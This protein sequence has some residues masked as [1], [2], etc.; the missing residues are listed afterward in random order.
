MDMGSDSRSSC[1]ELVC[2]LALGRQAVNHCSWVYIGSTEDAAVYVVNEAITIAC[3]AWDPEDE[4]LCLL[5][6]DL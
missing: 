4:L 5:A 1:A 2:C 3:H 6:W